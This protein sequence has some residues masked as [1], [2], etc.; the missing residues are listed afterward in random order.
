MIA[1]YNF[2]Y[3]PTSYYDGGFDAMI[4]GEP[5]VAPYQTLIQAAG[6]RPVD[7]LYL[8]VSLNYI[9][10]SELQIH[11]EVARQ[12]HAPSVASQP[13]TDCVMFPSGSSRSFSTQATEPDGEQILYRWAF[14][15]G[16]SSTWM[17]PYNSGDTCMV[18]YQ[19][20]TPGQYDIKILTKDNYQA[21]AAWSAP[22]TITV[23]CLCG[24]ANNSATVNI[25]DAVFLIAYIFAGGTAPGPCACSGTGNAQGDASGDG[26]INISD[27]VYLIAYIFAGG[28]P[29][30]CE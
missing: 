29:P 6:I 3:V 7:D 1:K 25:S 23:D 8:M 19:W 24:D 18:S 16:D 4:G 14:G 5:G 12:N 28:P 21:S 13:T 9:S 30:H 27:A 17:G 2:L 10:T 11:Y 15:N 20:T 22:M 26:K